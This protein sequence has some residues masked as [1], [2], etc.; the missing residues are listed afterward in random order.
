MLNKIDRIDENLEILIHFSDKFKLQ[1]E[2]IEI[3]AFKNYTRNHL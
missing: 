3:H 2:N 1:F